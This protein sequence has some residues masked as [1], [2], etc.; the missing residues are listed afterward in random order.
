MPAPDLPFGPLQSLVDDPTSQVIRVNRYDRILVSRGG[1]Q[2]EVKDV[3]FVDDVSVRLF[4][5]QV[6][7]RPTATLSDLVHPLPGDMLLVAHF[8]PLSQHVTVSLF[9]PATRPERWGELIAD[10]VLPDQAARE[11]TTAVHSGATVLI[12]GPPDSGKKTLLNV[13]LGTL[14]AAEPIAV[15]DES[16][17]LTAVRSSARVILPSG[18]SQDDAGAMLVA[19]AVRRKPTWIV[20]ASVLPDELS[21]LMAAMTT[22]SA[23]A[24]VSVPVSEVYKPKTL[25]EDLALRLGM[26]AGLDPP[27]VQRWL[28]EFAPL[29]VLTEMLPIHRNEPAR[30]R[31]A[32]IVALAG[33]PEAPEVVELWRCEPPRDELA[34]T[35]RTFVPV[36]RP[37]P[38]RVTHI[39]PPPSSAGSQ[40]VDAE[41]SE[42]VFGGGLHTTRL[43]REWVRPDEAFPTGAA[44]DACAACV[45]LDHAVAGGNEAED[46]VRGARRRRAVH[47]SLHSELQLVL[48]RLLEPELAAAYRDPHWTS[49]AAEPVLREPASG[50]AMASQVF[51]VLHRHRFGRYVSAVMDGLPDEPRLRLRDVRGQTLEL[52]GLSGGYRGHAP[53]GA[54]WV[55]QVAGV[56]DH[57]DRM[58]AGAPVTALEDFVFAHDRFSREL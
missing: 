14:P 8:P 24:L 54:V 31:V 17:S 13:L 46:D 44:G 38:T 11:L 57:P 40:S 50:D 6:T 42:D 51:F 47:R 27:R 9:K 18:P 37:D 3:R 32:G 5:E 20:L 33:K 41:P 52:R 2:E 26:E 21:A 39:P 30:W 43:I 7:G 15:I 49:E 4:V 35:G 34:P 55:L 56:D 25:V 16:R 58:E 19:E 12:V 48:E 22:S 23:Q 1:R 28:A 45:A 10:G 29:V 36:R 53:R